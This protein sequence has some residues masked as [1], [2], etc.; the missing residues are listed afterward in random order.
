MT[1]WGVVGV[2]VV[3]VGFVAALAKPMISLNTAI[4]RLTLAVERLQ[5]DVSA[6]TAKNSESHSRIYGK[7]EGQD[8]RIDE[9][10][11]RIAL[12]ETRKEWEEG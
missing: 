9:H 11:G 3:L 6:M 12:L 5:H 8:K 4:T 1:E 7:L 2:L 10:E